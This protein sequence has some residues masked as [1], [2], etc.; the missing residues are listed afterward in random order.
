MQ[1]ADEA[2]CAVSQPGLFQA[3]AA[4]DRRVSGGWRSGR[5]VGYGRAAASV[6]ERPQLRSCGEPVSWRRGGWWCSEGP[7]E[8]L[9]RVAR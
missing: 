4:G 8:P 1:D 2:D 5:T 6:S 7:E 9:R 3:E